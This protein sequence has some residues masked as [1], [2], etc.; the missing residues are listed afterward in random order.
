MKTRLSITVPP[1]IQYAAV[2]SPGK[3]NPVDTNTTTPKWGHRNRDHY[4]QALL[5]IL[6]EGAWGTG[7]FSKAVTLRSGEAVTHRLSW[8]SGIGFSAAES[9]YRKRFGKELLHWVEE[10]HPVCARRLYNCAV[11]FSRAL[12]DDEHTLDV[13]APDAGRT[14]LDL[15]AIDRWAQR[16]AICGRRLNRHLS[17]SL[18]QLLGSYPLD[19]VLQVTMDANHGRRNRILAAMKHLYQYPCPWPHETVTRWAYEQLGGWFCREL[20]TAIGKRSA[21]WPF[22]QSEY[23]LEIPA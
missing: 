19:A 9:R 5:D 18:R 2:I 6:V 3:T 23:E 10:L 4:F 22:H 12:P 8:C 20:E 16:Y 15:K 7:S 11:E 1:G 17:R 13:R 14:T 21:L